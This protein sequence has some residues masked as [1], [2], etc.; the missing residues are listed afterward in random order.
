MDGVNPAATNTAWPTISLSTYNGYIRNGATGAKPLNLP[1]ITIGGA[2]TALVRRPPVGES[3]NDPVLYGERL[4]SKVSLRIMLSDVANDISALPTVTPTAPVQLDGNWNAA[5]PNN[6]TA[7]GPISA[8]T[9]PI[10][11]S[12]GVQTI[13]TA[14]PTAA[15]AAFIEI[16]APA[17]GNFFHTPV[18][19]L[20]VSWGAPVQNVQMNC[21]VVIATPT[22]QFQ[23][24]TNN[25]GGNLPNIPAGAVMNSPVVD[26][27]SVPVTTINAPGAGNN[28]T[29]TVST[30]VP[31]AS[32]TFFMRDKNSLA[33]NIVTCT[34]WGRPPAVASLRLTNCTGVPATNAG[35]NV[36]TT[37]ALQARDSG[38][39]GGFIK[40]DM[41]DAAGAWRD[42]TMEILNYGIGDRNQAG[43][44][45]GDPSPN[46]ILRIQ[47][48]RDNA[49][50]CHY[51][52]STIASDYWPQTL[53]DPREALLRD[54]VPLDV[55]ANIQKDVFFGGVMH[56]IAL[57]VRNLS[58]WFQGAGAYAGGSG[59]Q[60]F[61]TGGY[62]VYFSDRRN[63]RNG[64][65]ETGEYGFEDFVNP[66]SG[67]GTPNGV[68]DA[69]ED[70][71]ANNALDTYG[72]FPAYNGVVNAQPPGAIAPLVA[73][74]RP[75]T[76]IDTPGAMT[77]RA[78]FFR[79]A[80]KLVNGGLGNI[81]AP[82]F[83]VVTENPVYVQGDWNASQAGFSPTDGHVATSVIADA[84]TL[85]SNEW[86]DRNSYVNPYCPVANTGLCGAANQRNR[87]TPAFYRLAI[88]GGKGIAF[89]QPAATATDFGTDGGAHNFL[90]YLENGNQ[91]VNYRGSIATFFYNRQAVGTF[92][93]CTTVYSAPARNYAFDTDFLNPALLPPLTPVFRD[94][95]ALGFSQELRPG[96]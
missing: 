26:G 74:S 9:P 76:Q 60:A 56:Y 63:N 81:V 22:P 72:Q 85:L 43:G 49:S 28:L 33:W 14:Q 70:I 35:A 46:A 66:A 86:T 75:W 6:G 94:L 79:R 20:T 39:I 1:L 88:I 2:N 58:R 27:V 7:Y 41:Q 44:A 77:S 45:C 29:Y 82:G 12:A 87:G 13:S 38:T 93:C 16:T 18:F 59:P 80:L 24:C 96:K 4:Y 68:L 51:A 61:N 83:T 23:N 11:R 42:V 30:T 95:N 67:T 8:A 73:V 57:D 40:I 37:D 69:G 92:K 53:F 64:N 89:P 3:V 15:N 10:A 50:V 34:G 90:R 47:R 91:A 19:P 71:N 52:N 32:N 21:T 31:F 62:S 5:V 65:V 36:I 25:A 84:V 78:I 17:V 55:N 48:L 54:T